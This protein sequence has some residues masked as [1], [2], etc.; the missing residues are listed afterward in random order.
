MSLLDPRTPEE[1]AS[2]GWIFVLAAL[3]AMLLPLAFWNRFYLTPEA[4]V[5][6]G[7]G[8][9]LLGLAFGGLVHRRTRAM[10]RRGLHP[11]FSRRMP[12]PGGAIV[13][14]YLGMV[15]LA[16]AWVVIVLAAASVLW[17]P[18]S[19]RP[20]TIL[21]VRH[22]TRKCLSCFE[23]LQ[24]LDWPGLVTA[25]VCGDALHD[26]RAGTR[27]VVRGRFEGPVIQVQGVRAWTGS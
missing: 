16:W 8:G 2:G 20:F 26:V 19:E 3:G 6:A 10:V 21:D 14:L 5:Q 15:L 9:A 24:L 12:P 4:V 18:V 17:T 13:S 11:Q 25:R 22:C 1:V 23:Q 7:A 27:I